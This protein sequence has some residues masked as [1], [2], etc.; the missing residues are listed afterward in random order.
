MNDTHELAIQQQGQLAQRVSPM[1]ALAV[2]SDTEF[3]QRLDQMKTAQ[4]RMATIQRELMTTEVDYG[5]IPGTGSKPTLLKPGAEKLAKFHHLVPTFDQTTILGDGITTPQLRVLSVCN[6]HAETED[7]PIV[8]QGLG[9]ANSWEKKHRYRDGQRKCPQCGAAAIIKGKAEY[10]GGYLC[11][12]KKGGC[13][14]KFGDNDPSI[15]DQQQGQIENP[16]PFDNENTLKKMSAKR[17]L[18]GS[19]PL[20]FR[21][22]L[23]EVAGTVEGMYRIYQDGNEPLQLPAPD[24]NWVDVEAMVRNENDQLFRIELGDGSY[25][26]ATA[27][28]RFPTTPTGLLSVANLSVGTSLL[29]SLIPI[30]DHA[31]H[32]DLPFAFAAGLF[33]A[34]GN[35]EDHYINYTLNA[36]RDDLVD[37]IQT[38]A[39]KLGSPLR[40]TRDKRDKGECLRVCISGPAFNGMIQQFVDGKGASGKHLSRYA[41]RQGSAFLQ[42]LLNGYLEG[43]GSFRDDEGRRPYWQIGFKGENY[44]WANDLR[45]L[46][47]VLG[48]RLTLRR[49][50]AR[51]KET[52]YPVFRGRLTTEPPA[53]HPKDLEQIVS[54]TP[55]KKL[56]PTYDIQVS[57][58]HIFLLANGIQTHNSY[59]DAT[60]RATATSGLFSQ[61]LEDMAVEPETARRP[62]P[63][64]PTTRPV[65]RAPETTPMQAKPEA[66]KPET[67]KAPASAGPANPWPDIPALHNA[68]ELMTWAHD[69]MSLASGAVL[70]ALSIKTTSQI[71]DL[72]KAAEQ[73]R[74]YYGQKPEV[75][76]EFSEVP[77]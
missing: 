52:D 42:E 35:A 44:D 73:V 63:V 20:L 62:E 25:I 41:W 22:S 70:Q 30:K 74:A 37:N 34:E 49:S 17:C 38:A 45:S 5:V 48:H 36:G 15:I 1:D 75:K 32:A 43:D 29:R 47:A 8:G 55:E 26:R 46:C 71:G 12:A 39:M 4:V 66:S 50:N 7:G 14:A 10:G 77:A 72:Q 18:G 67:F 9:A 6:L 53:Y 24:G 60:L 40:V 3:R 54:I 64:K 65:S 69:A 27:L 16:D 68:G 19:T 58:E 51:Y 28:H 31:Q 56:A 2:M 11:F 23:G 59:V 13:G 57:G 76:D 33:I 61:D 21:T